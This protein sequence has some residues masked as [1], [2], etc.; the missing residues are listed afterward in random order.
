MKATIKCPRTDPRHG[1]RIY[2]SYC[3]KDCRYRAEC[4]TLNRV[5]QTIKESKEARV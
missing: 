3:K 4:G 2:L 1:T 5:Q